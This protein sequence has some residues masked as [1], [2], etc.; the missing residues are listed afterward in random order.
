VDRKSALMASFVL[1]PPQGVRAMPIFITARLGDADDRQAFT[2]SQLAMAQDALHEKDAPDLVSLIRLA[3][4][5]DSLTDRG[6][7]IP[8]RLPALWA[9]LDRAGRAE[10][11]LAAIPDP[12]RRANA[13]SCASCP[14][15][16]LRPCR[17][18]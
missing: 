9:M 14:G 12:S 5:R 18:P 1:D 2:L 7:R 17:G 8:L 11:L 16:D 13:P 15:R 6:G 10:T 4:H 3:I